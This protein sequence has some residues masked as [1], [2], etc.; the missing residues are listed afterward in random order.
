M[1][2]SEKRAMSKCESG[3]VLSNSIKTLMEQ[4]AKRRPGRSRL[5]YDK[6]TRTIV[7]VNPQTGDKKPTGLIIHD[8]D[9]MF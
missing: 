9:S 2:L 5:V 4:I 8:D 6:A 7:C 1:K 3:S